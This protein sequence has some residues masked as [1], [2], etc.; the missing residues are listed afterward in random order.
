MTVTDKYKQLQTNTMTM[1][2]GVMNMTI[3]NNYND[4]D[5]HSN[6]HDHNSNDNVKVH[7]SFASMLL[8][9]RILIAFCFACVVLYGICLTVITMTMTEMTM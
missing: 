4:H 5:H 9:T 7:N 3:T 8:I 2:I 1:T 6:N